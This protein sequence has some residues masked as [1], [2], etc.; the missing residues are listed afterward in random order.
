[1]ARVYIITFG[2]DEDV[3]SH[4]VKPQNYN[5]LYWESMFHHA[6]QTK[7]RTRYYSQFEIN[8]SLATFNVDRE[9]IDSITERIIENNENGYPDN[10]KQYW[11]N[12]VFNFRKDFG[13]KVIETGIPQSQFNEWMSS[14]YKSYLTWFPDQF[15]H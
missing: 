15:N 1:M 6:I 5:D 14:R 2:T 12:F 8:P 7:I 11:K 13:I 10:V 4:V 3:N 9:I